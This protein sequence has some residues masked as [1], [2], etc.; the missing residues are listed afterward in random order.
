MNDSF[1]EQQHLAD[2]EQGCLDL[3][4]HL[5]QSIYDIKLGRVHSIDSAVSD[6]FANIDKIKL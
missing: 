2:K 5:A 4:E 3:Y 1:F 6:I